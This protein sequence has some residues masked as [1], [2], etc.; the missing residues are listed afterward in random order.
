MYTKI[1]PTEFIK[2]EGVY[3]AYIPKNMK[4]RTSTATNYDRITGDDMRGYVMKIK[5]TNDDTTKTEL[6]KVDINSE[7]SR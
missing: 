5:M 4:T 7:L 3:K 1:L 6:F 2:E